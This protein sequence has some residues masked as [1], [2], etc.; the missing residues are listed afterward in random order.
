MTINL[1]LS[2]LLHLT[3]PSTKPDVE[4]LDLETAMSDPAW[5]GAVPERPRWSPDSASIRFDRRRGTTEERDVFEIDPVTG[6]VVELDDEAADRLVGSGDWNRDRTS[7]VTTRNGD[8]VLFDPASGGLDQLTRTTTIEYRPRFL[9]DGRIAF[10]RDGRTIIRDLGRGTEIEPASIRFEDPPEPPADPTGLAADQR[11]LF[12]TLRNRAE[13]RETGRLRSDARRE[14]RDHDVTGP[15]RLDPS[16][17]ETRRHLSPDARWMLIE[18][19]PAGRVQR[20]SDDMPVFVTDDGYVDVRSIRPKVGTIER[21][22][23]R[24]F[25]VDLR[26]GVAREIDL[27]DLPERRVDRLASIRAENTAWRE[28]IDAKDAGDATDPPADPIAPASALRSRIERLASV[29]GRD[30]DAE[31]PPETD[32]RPLSIGTVAWSDD[33]ALAAI[34]ARSLDNKDRW[35]VVVAPDVAIEGDG[36]TIVEHLHDPAWIGWRFNE[37][38]WLRDRDTLWFLSEGLGWSDLMT[39]RPVDAVDAEAL[40]PDGDQPPRDEAVAAETRQGPAGIV[41]PLVAGRFE[42]RSVQRHP[43]DDML[44]YRS[45]RDDPSQWRVERVDP[46]TGRTESMIDDPGMVE[47]FSISPDGERV[48]FMHSNLEAPAELHVRTTESRSTGTP[49][50]THSTTPRFDSIERHPPVL[51]DVPGRH[52]RPI[53][54]RLH[55]PP[56][57]TEDD[58]GGRRPAVLF[59]HGAGYLQNA[60]A[61]WSRYFR[62]GMFHD[63]LAREGFVVL[64]LDY[65]ASAGY[66][67]DWRTAIARNMG[68]PELDDLE[69][70]IAWLVEN[71]RVDPDRVGVY[72]GSYGGFLTLMGLFTRPELFACGAALRPVTDWSHYNDGYTANILNTPDVDPMAFRRSSPIEHAEGLERPL[73]ICHGMVDDN[74]PFQDTVRLAQRLIELGKEDWEV[75]IY[76]VEPHGFRTPSSWLD[77]YRRI[78]GLF[79]E[80][81]LEPTGAPAPDT[82]LP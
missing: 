6:T 36:T 2:L 44:W 45:N 20:K 37:M 60:H 75:A 73:L 61:G 15:V 64:D 3:P 62:E 33:G 50:L 72:G 47:S 26:D 22:P 29:A 74:V 41:E 35:I 18:A 51:V 77:E 49:P 46:S 81:L 55:L 68:P 38:G 70:G 69:D 40:V 13:A 28:A 27:D 21:T 11:R 53:R 48:L 65:R 30:S 39:W 43:T 19:A 16:L 5:I 54:G 57:G 71:H 25:L 66:G 24:L 82:M 59:I 63:L 58:R 17:R 78:R 31:H 8:L 12:E 34:Q 23:E 67:R 32:P 52:G 1:A 10:E 80:H 56:E 76:P 9:R 14:A 79:R 7:M 42:V 4:T